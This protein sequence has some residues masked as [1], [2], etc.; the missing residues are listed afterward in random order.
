MT[1]L[2]QQTGQMYLSGCLSVCSFVC[3]SIRQAVCLTVC[4]FV[5]LPVWLNVTASGQPDR[6]SQI[7]LDVWRL[8]ASTIRELSWLEISIKL[9]LALL[10]FVRFKLALGAEI[11]DEKFARFVLLLFAGARLKRDC[12]SISIISC[13]FNVSMLRNSLSLQF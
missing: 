6:A 4:L 7:L 12:I 9:K 5:C 13:G 11:F 8:F 2:A 10:F 3:L 1:P